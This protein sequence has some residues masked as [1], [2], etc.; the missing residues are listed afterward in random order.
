[1]CLRYFIL[2]AIHWDR[3]HHKSR[4][5]VFKSTFI[6]FENSHTVRTVVHFLLTCLVNRGSCDVTVHCTLSCSSICKES[7]YI[8]PRR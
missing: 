7:T 4:L 8:V 6:L 2:R 3:N 5:L 1:M